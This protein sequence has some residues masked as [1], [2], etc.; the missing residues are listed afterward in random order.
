MWSIKK[1]IVVLLIV[2]SKYVA[3]TEREF[4]YSHSGALIIFMATSRTF[5]ATVVDG[6]SL[7][8]IRV[9]DIY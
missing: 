2:N 4:F 5:Y 8:R 3:A 1:L 9:V 7:Q 6:G